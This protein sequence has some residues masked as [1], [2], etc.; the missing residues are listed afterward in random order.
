MSEQQKT[1][2]EAAL[3]A[4]I[5]FVLF[6]FILWL[7]ISVQHASWM[8][9]YGI[10]I[11]FTPENRF[12]EFIM[13]NIEQLPRSYVFVAT[14]PVMLGVWIGLALFVFVWH[15]FTEFGIWLH[16]LF[17]LALSLL[18]FLIAFLISKELPID[19]FNMVNN[20]G[21]SHLVL[22][23]IVTVLFALITKKQRAA[24]KAARANIQTMSAED[25]AKQSQKASKPVDTPEDKPFVPAPPIL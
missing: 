15:R 5:Y 18:T 14:T 24:A 25:F 22:W 19:T 3:I 17:G 2:K 16:L 7:V 8:F 11:I 10:A 1:T 4:L 12:W 13:M 21:Y 23:T 6:P 9:K 20:V